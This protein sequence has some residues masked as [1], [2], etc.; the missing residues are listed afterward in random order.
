MFYVDNVK[1]ELRM[2]LCNSTKT[3]SFDS[4]QEKF[5]LGEDVEALGSKMWSEGYSSYR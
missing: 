3:L 2:L 4:S 5:V 1:D